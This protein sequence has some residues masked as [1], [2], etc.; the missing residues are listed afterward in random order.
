VRTV[1][2]PTRRFSLCAQASFKAKAMQKNAANDNGNR[3]GSFMTP[4]MVCVQFLFWSPVSYQHRF[5]G[6]GRGLQ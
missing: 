6:G 1:R 2:K 5:G 3:R 4:P